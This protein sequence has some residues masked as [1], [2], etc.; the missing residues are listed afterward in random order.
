[1][2][3]L[4]LNGIPY[5]NSEG[6][7]GIA[8]YKETILYDATDVTFKNITLSDSLLNYDA[9]I[10]HVHD[11]AYAG[12][13]NAQQSGGYIY[14]RQDILGCMSSSLKQIWLAGYGNTYATYTLTDETHLTTNTNVTSVCN[15]I[16]GIKYGKCDTQYIQGALD[17]SEEEKVI[18]TWIDNKP[19]YQKSFPIT[20]TITTTN[21]TWYNAINPTTLALLN[22]ENYIG[23]Q[24]SYLKFNDSRI[25]IPYSSIVGT[26]G[27][28]VGIN[29]SADGIE[30]VISGFSAQTATGCITMQ[31]TKTTDSA[32][33]GGYQAYGFSPIIYSTIEREVGV[34]TNG[35]PLYQKTVPFGRLTNNYSLSLGVSN[36][37]YA[38]LVPDGC[39]AN[40]SV[41][42]IP[43]VIGNGSQNNIGG[44]FNITSSD[45]SFDFRLGS[46]SVSDTVNGYI[47][48]RYT[49]T[50]DT[51]GS[52][53]YTTLGVPAVHYTEDEQVIGT[54]LGKPFY[55]KTIHVIEQSE[56]AQ[57]QYQAEI[58]TLDAEM[59]F[60]D[61]ASIK[62]GAVAGGIWINSPYYNSANYN[63]SIAV[64]VNEMTI[65]ATGWNFTEA[66]VTV[67]YTK[68]TD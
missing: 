37:E 38:F 33:S 41:R 62:L 32:N 4:I 51:A 60:L 58:Q 5:G 44:Y 3:K 22:I 11:T 59:I 66:V 57:K 26:T 27:G 23:Y 67:K 55:Q 49:K 12:T 46:G 28:L 47:T 68:T 34:W 15:R 17:Y 61:T 7:R 54:Y 36:V 16:I 31:Y 30:L 6:K 10:F 19:L 20:I 64:T 18:G 52:G 53:K 40:D 2:G 50:T 1:M 45:T 48:F 35:K 8:P 25:E 9:I 63:N 65:V 39:W 21:R 43:Y 29:E 14:S 24:G 42:P 56:V 13:N